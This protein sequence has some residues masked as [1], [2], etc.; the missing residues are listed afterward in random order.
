MTI[1]CPDGCVYLESA[2]RHPPSAERRQAVADQGVI[3]PMVEGLTEAQDSLLSLVVA[4]VAHHEP[5]PLAELHDED[6]IE[7][8]ETMAATDETASRGI[9]YEHRAERPG[10]RRLAGDIRRAVA[11]LE[12]HGRRVAAADLIV[13]LR[14]VAAAA[15]LAGRQ[16][17]SGS[18]VFLDLLQRVSR[19]FETGPA[20]RATSVGQ[21]VV[22]DLPP[23]GGG[24]IVP[25]RG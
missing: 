17:G 19:G 1:D 14:R 3:A 11:A 8:V 16:G 20:D 2:R 25:G 9:I 6:V 13:V 15:R 18:R 12:A 21:S 22:S 4:V 7:A 24:L 5:D 10:A 23:V